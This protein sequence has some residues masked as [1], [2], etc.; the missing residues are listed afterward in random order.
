MLIMILDIDWQEKADKLRNTISSYLED[1]GA[2][3]T[4]ISI[5]EKYEVYIEYNYKD[6][7]VE[8]LNFKI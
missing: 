8:T 5:S 7:V 2:L 6:D 4:K 3:V 1:F